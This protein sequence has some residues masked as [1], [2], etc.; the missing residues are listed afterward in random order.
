MGRSLSPPLSLLYSA[1]SLHT[2]ASA[3]EP[4]EHLQPGAWSQGQRGD[5]GRDCVASSWRKRVEKELAVAVRGVGS[6]CVC[7]RGR[8]EREGQWVLGCG[9]GPWPERAVPR[10]HSLQWLE[11]GEEQ[12]C[13]KLSTISAG[14]GVVVRGPHTTA[15]RTPFRWPFGAGEPAQAVPHPQLQ[16][17]AQ[18][19]QVCPGDESGSHPGVGSLET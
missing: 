6:G 17:A 12:D 16:L 11:L 3:P 10:P 7:E 9:V 8:R 19:P 14:I 1:C 13:H 15:P 5:S 2:P 4:M 18:S